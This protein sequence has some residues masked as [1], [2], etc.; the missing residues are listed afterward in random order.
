MA[1]S[2]LLQMLFENKILKAWNR[3][4]TFIR[5]NALKEKTTSDRRHAFRHTFQIGR[6]QMQEMQNVSI[7]MKKG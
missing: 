5:K 4:R 3:M 2:K 6:W 7:E 1:Y